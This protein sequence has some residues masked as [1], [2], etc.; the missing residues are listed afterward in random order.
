MQKFS[1]DF[2]KDFAEELSTECF[3]KQ[4]RFFSEDPRAGLSEA[5]NDAVE[6][7][8][9]RLDRYLIELEKG[10]VNAERLTEISKEVFI[11]ACGSTKSTEECI[12]FAQQCGLDK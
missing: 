7:M 11:I 8:K 1:A 3:D 10:G 6:G 5:Q 2:V 4:P 9:Y 12:K